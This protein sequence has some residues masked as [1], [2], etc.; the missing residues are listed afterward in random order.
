MKKDYC[1]RCE[2]LREDVQNNLCRAHRIEANKV[3]NAGL[4]RLIPR[5]DDCKCRITRTQ[6]RRNGGYCDDC[7][8]F[9]QKDVAKKRNRR[10]RRLHPL[11]WL[12]DLDLTKQQREGVERWWKRHPNQL[13]K[14][15]ENSTRLRSR[16]SHY[17]MSAGE[18]MVMVA[19]QDGKCGICR[20][21]PD[22]DVRSLFVDHDHEDGHVR[23]LLCHGCNVG[24]GW[25]GVDGEQSIVRLQSALAYV[26]RRQAPKRISA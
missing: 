23:G 11:D 8:L 15:T 5:C 13:D 17:G 10:A 2:E 20:S 7:V 25:L 4:D 6:I 24:L 9:H 1:F 14:I 21:T 26:R 3:M 19:E 16:N 12:H 22:D 18:W